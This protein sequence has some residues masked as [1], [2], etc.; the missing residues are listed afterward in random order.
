[1]P[2]KLLG[3]AIAAFMGLEN[4]AFEC[5]MLA[6]SCGAR[7]PACCWSGKA[8]A[9]K[10]LQTKQF[11][12]LGL[13]KGAFDFIIIQP[14]RRTVRLAILPAKCAPSGHGDM[15][16]AKTTQPFTDPRSSFPLA[17]RLPSTNNGNRGHR[18]QPQ[19]SAICQDL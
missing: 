7:Y 13:I 6:G 11:E 9:L 5:G 16:G 4:G 17:T 15:G 19:Q 18:R 14:R 8:K 1:M 3:E 12:N 10:L 2:D